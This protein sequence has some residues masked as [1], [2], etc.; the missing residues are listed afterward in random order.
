MDPQ[1]L[2]VTPEPK[3]PL[4][5]SSLPTSDKPELTFQVMPQAGR[6]IHEQRSEIPFV[7][8][9]TPVSGAIQKPGGPP[10]RMPEGELFSDTDGSFWQGKLPFIIIGIVVLLGLGLLAYFFIGS[11]KSNTNQPQQTQQPT[12]KLP[13]VWL[14]QYFGKD[15]CD[16]V[17][18]CGDDADPDKDGLKNYDEFKAGTNPIK[19][20]TDEDGLADGDEV[21][22]YKTEPTLRYTDRRDVVA[23]NNWTDGIQIKG[24]YDPLTPGLKFTDTRNQQIANDIVKFSL[25]E[26]TIT[27]LQVQK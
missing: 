27:T 12:T 21:N 4:T 5:P 10:P 24:G 25:H 2:P 26:P 11:K 1:I 23:S 6:E 9:P 13:K 22:I 8:G 20:D 15:T 18:N 19:A 14:S 16:D 3:T 17:S 7:K